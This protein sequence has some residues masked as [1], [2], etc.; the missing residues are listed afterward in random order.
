[1]TRRA[2]SWQSGCVVLSMVWNGSASQAC[3]KLFAHSQST[4]LCSASPTARL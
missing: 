3:L 1:L 2:G 4:W